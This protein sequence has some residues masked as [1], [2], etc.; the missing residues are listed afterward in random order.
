M[1]IQDYI[2]LDIFL[3]TLTIDNISAIVSPTVACFIKQMKG[4]ELPVEP[5]HNLVGYISHMPISEIKTAIFID[6][7]M[8]PHEKL[9]LVNGKEIDLNLI[10]DYKNIELI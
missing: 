3:S 9:I 4:F 7:Y 10:E 2:K 1:E 8:E 5:S 6:P